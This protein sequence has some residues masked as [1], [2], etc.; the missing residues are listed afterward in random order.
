MDSSP[1]IVGWLLNAFRGLP[2][3]EDL[4]KTYFWETRR[5]GAKEA[6]LYT[7]QKR[8]RRLETLWRAQ[9]YSPAER[10]I[11]EGEQT[12]W[13]SCFVVLQG[14]RL[15]WW[16]SLHDFDNAEQPVGNLLLAGHAGVADPSPLELREVEGEEVER[17]VCLFGRGNQRQERV[18]VLLPS[19]E[20]KVCLEKAIEDAFNCKGD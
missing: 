5:T 19:S 17:L 1:L 18:T 8:K 4:R 3:D 15:F 12:F 16:E 7:S 13:K 9:W 2:T 20:A 11:E 10:F 14:H 6:E